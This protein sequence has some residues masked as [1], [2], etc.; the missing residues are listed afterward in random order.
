MARRGKARLGAPVMQDRAVK[1]AVRVV[2]E[3]GRRSGGLLPDD[4][5][6]DRLPAHAERTSRCCAESP[7]AFRMQAA[8]SW[9][10]AT[11]SSSP[12]RSSVRAMSLRQLACG[13]L[14]PKAWLFTPGASTRGSRIIYSYIIFQLLSIQG[15][16]C[17]EG[18][19]CSVSYIIR[20][21]AS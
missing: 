2:L 1:W 3:V 20:L 5:G 15:N 4:S 18:M 10:G 8:G 17:Y 6:T 21:L 9:A 19:Q 11:G 12:V 7:C 14:S 13:W 16:R